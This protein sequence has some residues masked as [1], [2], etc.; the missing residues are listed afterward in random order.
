MPN[1]KINLPTVMR[2]DADGQHTIDITADSV[3]QSLMILTNQY[4]NLRNRL[5]ASNLTLH[6]FVKIFIDGNEVV[7]DATG[8]V[9]P[10]NDVQIDI[11]SAVAGG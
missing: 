10:N 4:P 11:L 3:R 8:D 1:F 5:F 9:Y 7:L 2:S 6:P